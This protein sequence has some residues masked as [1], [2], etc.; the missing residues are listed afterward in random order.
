MIDTATVRGM[1]ELRRKPKG[2]AR[3]SVAGIAA[4]LTAKVGSFTQQTL[5]AR[6]SP[7]DPDARSRES[8]TGEGF[9]RQPA[10]WST[11]EAECALQVRPI[12][13]R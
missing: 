5:G 1:I 4:R 12:A 7:H 3:F 11:D 9:G 10:A 13:S 2:R 8:L 6:I